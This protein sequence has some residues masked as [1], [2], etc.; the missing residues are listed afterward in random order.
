MS[1]SRS[2]STR[3]LAVLLPSCFVWTA[4]ACV[5]L[6]LKYSREAQQQERPPA[7]IYRIADT[8]DGDCCPISR[9]P[10]TA[11][12][13]RSSLIQ[14]SCSDGAPAMRPVD[15]AEHVRAEYETDRS[16]PCYSDPPFE[17]LRNI[18]I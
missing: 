5:T 8:D 3:F 17:R 15:L 2:I 13:G 18:R 4:V 9:S 14:P 7:A 10:I 16:P 12:P 11:L 6:C 1:P